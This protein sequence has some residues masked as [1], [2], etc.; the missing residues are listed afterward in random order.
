MR[1]STL[2]KKE[3]YIF[4]NLKQQVKQMIIKKGLYIFFLNLFLYLINSKKKL[5]IRYIS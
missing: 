2:T 5:E 3:V 4:V 1:S